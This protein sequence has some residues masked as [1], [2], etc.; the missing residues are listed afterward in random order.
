MQSMKG[1]QPQ[2]HD[3]VVNG[4]WPFF[5][6]TKDTWGGASSAEHWYFKVYRLSLEIKKFLST[7]SLKWQKLIKTG[8]YR[9]ISYIQ[10]FYVRITKDLRLYQMVLN[11]QLS[12]CSSWGPAL[13]QMEPQVTSCGR[14]G[15]LQSETSDVTK[16]WEY[17]EFIW[18]N[19]VW[20]D[21]SHPQNRMIA[22]LERWPKCR[23]ALFCT[24]HVVINS[25]T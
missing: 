11:L 13:V 19:G 4:Q 8:C 5:L 24:W 10:L 3:T 9:H 22:W 21:R 23:L 20:D 14:K 15:T 7:S 16:S 1:F 2:E 25:S 6:H 17:N 18:L 12:S